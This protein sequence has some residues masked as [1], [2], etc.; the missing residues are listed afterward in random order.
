MQVMEKNEL[1]TLFVTCV[2]DTRKAVLK[3]R[4][5]SEMDTKKRL[6]SLGRVNTEA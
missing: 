2:E 1:E 3:R 6:S 4:L 5:K